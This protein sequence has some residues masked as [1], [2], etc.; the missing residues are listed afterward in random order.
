ML[1]Q[2]TAA[3]LV[4]E[5][6]GLAHPASVD[7]IPTGQ[8]HEDHVSM[9]PAAA[10]TLDLVLDAV[11]QVLAIEVLVAAQGLDFRADDTPLCSAMKDTLE[12]VRARVP[13]WTEDRVLHRDLAQ[14]ADLVRSG[15]LA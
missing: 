7:S 9:G 3:S 11:E 8:H 2:Y 1:A 6:K 14:V 13:R 12:G 4:S 15:A 5:C 10:K